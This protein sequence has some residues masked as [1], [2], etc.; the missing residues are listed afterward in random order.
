MPLLATCQPA[1]SLRH[2]ATFIYYRL[3]IG[4]VNSTD[5]FGHAALKDVSAV[6]ILFSRPFFPRQQAPALANL[7]F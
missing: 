7:M 1:K 2:L 6:Q 4:S 3:L 5:L